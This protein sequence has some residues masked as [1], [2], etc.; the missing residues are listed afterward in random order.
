LFRAT[1]LVAKIAQDR[2]GSPQNM[3]DRPRSL[4]IAPD[5]SDSPRSQQI[6]PDHPD[7]HTLAHILQIAQTA[8]ES[9]SS[10]GIAQDRPRSFQ[11]APDRPTSAHI[12]QIAAHRLRLPRSP[13]IA[14]TLP[15]LAKIGPD[16]PRSLQIKQIIHI[17]PE[18]PR[19]QLHGACGTPPL[20]KHRWRHTCGTPPNT[21]SCIARSCGTPPLPALMSVACVEFLLVLCRAVGAI[22]CVNP[23]L[24]A[25]TPVTVYIYIYI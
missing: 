12:L 5:R 8:P 21:R 7:R 15:E 19:F 1:L 16:R 18:T 14:T 17:V 9:P 23:Q 24:S 11:I 22:V 3:P 6:A 2:L 13:R 25:L 4:Q 20:A 10:A